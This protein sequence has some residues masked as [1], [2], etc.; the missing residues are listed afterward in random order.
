MAIKIKAGEVIVYA[1]QRIDEQW[2]QAWVAS[3]SDWI[4]DKLAAGTV[5]KPL[6]PLAAGKLRIFGE[7]FSIAYHDSKA[8]IDYEQKRVY[9]NH[10]EQ[11][12]PQLLQLLAGELSQY[13]E[14]AIARFQ[15]EIGA[16]FSTLK[17][18]VYK[19]RWGSFSGKGVLAFNTLLIGAPKWVID[20]VVVHELCHYQVMA[21]NVQ[22]WRLVEQHYGERY[23]A[24]RRYLREHGEQLMLTND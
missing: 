11:H 22:F 1:P 9:L 24:A 2:L 19:S 14:A 7:Q 21:H 3:K 23:Q 8:T 5:K 18:R 13:L 15:G 4:H 6:N 10:L 17:V 16:Q 20:Y 12:W